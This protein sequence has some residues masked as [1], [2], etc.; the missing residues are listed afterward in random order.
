[1]REDQAGRVYEWED[2]VRGPGRA[3]ERAIRLAQKLPRVQSG[4]LGLT[5]G[6]A[7]WSQS[8]P[9]HPV[10][11]ALG[12][13]GEAA[14]TAEPREIRFWSSPWVLATTREG[15]AVREWLKTLR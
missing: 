15:A 8:W 13:A 11:E 3:Q 10:A 1:V 6:L 4:D 12:R 5:L 7:A 14:L 2:R 9:G